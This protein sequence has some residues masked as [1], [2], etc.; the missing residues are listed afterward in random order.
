MSKVIKYKFQT[1]PEVI[2]IAEDFCLESDS[3][4]PAIL[5]DRNVNAATKQMIHLAFEAFRQGMVA[6][7]LSKSVKIIRTVE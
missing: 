5:K 2:K 1:D 6:E 4:I 3:T 7:I